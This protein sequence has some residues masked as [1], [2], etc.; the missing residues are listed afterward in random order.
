MQP[1][2]DIGDETGTYTRGLTAYEKT[3]K[4]NKKENKKKKKKKEKT[5]T[6]KQ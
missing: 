6:M 4:E 5:D 1:E 2:E 3:E